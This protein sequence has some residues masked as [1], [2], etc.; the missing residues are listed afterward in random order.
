MR[1][2]YLRVCRTV[3]NCHAKLVEELF[4]VPT[5][6]FTSDEYLAQRKV[7]EQEYKSHQTQA[8]EDLREQAKKLNIALMQTPNGFALCPFKDGQ[9]VSPDEFLQ[10]SSA[11]QQEIETQVLASARQLTDDHAA[12]SAL[13]AR[14]P[15]EIEAA[16]Y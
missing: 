9:V 15:T 5:A 16:Q 1:C 11:E 7:L 10:F 6:A 13:A 4:T 2:V 8:L 12:D 3:A 14:S